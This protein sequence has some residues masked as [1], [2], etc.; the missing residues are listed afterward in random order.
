MTTWF[1]MNLKTADFQDDK[2]MRN[3]RE[4]QTDVRDGC[5]KR[6][7]ALARVTCLLCG[8]DCGL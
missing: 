3:D 1:Y 4:L 8:S 5:L 7:E 2:L 6:H